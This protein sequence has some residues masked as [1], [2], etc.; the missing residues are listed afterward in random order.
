MIDAHFPGYLPPKDVV[1]LALAYSTVYQ[2]G[3]DQVGF[4]LQRKPLFLR[5]I[6][7]CM[8]VLSILF[9]LGYF[10]G[11]VTLTAETFPR[12]YVLHI[13]SLL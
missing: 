5:A 13:L 4:N 10:L 7:H 9:V 11:C 3:L 6:S 8:L 2:L 12:K 1:Q